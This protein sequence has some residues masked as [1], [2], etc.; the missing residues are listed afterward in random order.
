LSCAALQL[1]A[2]SNMLLDAAAAEPQ[3][4]RGSERRFES[5]KWAAVIAAAQLLATRR[6]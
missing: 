6:V 4:L 1:L 3:W 5:S 2:H